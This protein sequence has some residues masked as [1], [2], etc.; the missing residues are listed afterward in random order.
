[1]PNASANITGNAGIKIDNFSLAVAFFENVGGFTASDIVI[2]GDI[3]GVSFTIT[4][5]GKDYH[6]NFTLP[7]DTDLA[8]FDVAFSPTSS[9]NVGGEDCSIE[10]NSVS[11]TYD[12]TLEIGSGIQPPDYDGSGEDLIITI[13]VIF[14]NIFYYSS[15]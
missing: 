14:Y 1:M 2:S 8:T 5:M 10:G 9:V 6:L 7:D 11:I 13:G 4:G 3:T 15:H 12:T